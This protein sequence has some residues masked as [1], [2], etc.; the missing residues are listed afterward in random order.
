MSN[1]TNTNQSNLNTVSYKDYIKAQDE[2]L[3]YFRRLCLKLAKQNYDNEMILKSLK[4]PTTEFDYQSIYSNRY[5]KELKFIDE[6][7][8]YMNN[9]FGCL[10]TD[11]FFVYCETEGIIVNSPVKYIKQCTFTEFCNIRDSMINAG[12]LD[13]DNHCLVT[14]V[15]TCLDILN[16]Y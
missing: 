5:K 11:S 12:G 13:E 15:N 1:T 3:M 7:N 6:L 9:T 4:Y 2:R 16:Q 8:H 14:N 10:L